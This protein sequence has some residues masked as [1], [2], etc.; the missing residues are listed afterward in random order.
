MSKRKEI[1]IVIFLTIT[2]LIF[3]WSKQQPDKKDIDKPATGST[4]TQGSSTPNTGIGY[5]QTIHPV[6]TYSNEEYGFSFNYQKGEIRSSATSGDELLV[7]EFYVC[8]GVCSVDT[9]IKIIPRVDLERAVELE[10]NNTITETRS[11]WQTSV[12]D[13]EVNNIDTK[14]INYQSKNTPFSY[15]KYIFNHDGHTY[16]VSG[17]SSLGILKTWRFN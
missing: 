7:K 9:T 8:T 16:V 6:Q 5:D 11:E 3:F 13:E 15:D 2:T 14:R 1:L 17:R 4:I 12:F 10:V